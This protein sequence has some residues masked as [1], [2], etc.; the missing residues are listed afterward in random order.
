[1]VIT[2]L[3]GSVF[4]QMYRRRNAGSNSVIFVFMSEEIYIC[5]V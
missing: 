5:A 3:C 4:L 2:V 1:M